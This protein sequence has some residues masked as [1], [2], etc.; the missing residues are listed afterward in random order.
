MEETNAT[1]EE[2]ETEETVEDGTSIGSTTSETE[3]EETETDWYHVSELIA[4]AIEKKQPS[5]E[6]LTTDYGDLRVVYSVTTGEMLVSFL[7]LAAISLFL[8]RWLFKAVWGR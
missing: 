3:P 2:N 7:L 4:N 8:L 6:I 1:P 5:A